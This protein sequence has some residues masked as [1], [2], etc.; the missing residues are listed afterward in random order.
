MI[1][2]DTAPD[3][4]PPRGPS[5]GSEVN[6]VGSIVDNVQQGVAMWKAA[7]VP[8]EPGNNGRLDQAY[9]ST[10]DGLR[11]EILENKNRSAPI[12]SEHI[13]FFLSQGRSRKVRHGTQGFCAPRQVSAITPRSLHQTKSSQFGARRNPN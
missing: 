12:E 10:P 11:I 3:P 4:P 7:G 6:P 13:H 2:L 9:V 1:I 8:V 5:R